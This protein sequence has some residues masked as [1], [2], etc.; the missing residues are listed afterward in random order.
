MASET[1]GIEKQ[2]FYSPTV[3]AAPVICGV[4]LGAVGRQALWSS[5]EGYVK[6][7]E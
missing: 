2:P 7:Q 1:L 3:E 4:Q 5:R 6:G